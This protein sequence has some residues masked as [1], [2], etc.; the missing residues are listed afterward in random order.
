MFGGVSLG[1]LISARSRD[2]FAFHPIQ[3]EQYNNIGVFF[4]YL[5]M[6]DSLSFT[7]QEDCSQ[8][9]MHFI[10]MIQTHFTWKCLIT[11]LRICGSSQ[12]LIQSLHR[13]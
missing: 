12:E 5:D 8:V 7:F 3:A 2:L 6:F 9:L 1:R 4:E 11:V 13:D 10:R